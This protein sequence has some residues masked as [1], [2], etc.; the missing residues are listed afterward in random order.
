[1]EKRDEAISQGGDR[2]TDNFNNATVED[3]K[4]SH[5]E[6]RDYTGSAKKTDP[7]EI[8]L[9]RKLDLCIMVSP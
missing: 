9:V 4:P 8:R 2:A 6:E 1:M 7:E 3:E 5:L